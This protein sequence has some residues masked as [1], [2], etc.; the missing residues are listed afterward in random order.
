MI[1]TAPIAIPADPAITAI[2]ERQYA[3][4]IYRNLECV[5][6]LVTGTS[7]DPD[8]FN[9]HSRFYARM[10]NLLSRHTRSLPDF[11]DV[12]PASEALAAL[13]FHCS[14]C[15]REAYWPALCTAN[16]RCFGAIRDH[17]LARGASANSED[18]FAALVSLFDRALK[19]YADSL[20][21]DP[22][23]YSFPRDLATIQASEW[24]DLLL[25]EAQR[26][27]AAGAA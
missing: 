15:H 21:D 20:S 7:R 4:F 24:A 12:L 2:L 11:A 1:S 8:A 5:S 18:D 25:Q 17:V 14:V 27:K 13:L 26:A 22:Q 16:E 9:R 10:I 23:A 6:H 19:E 3:Y